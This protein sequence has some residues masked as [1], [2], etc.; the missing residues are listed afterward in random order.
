MSAYVDIINI[1]IIVIVTVVVAVAII[2]MLQIGL[3]IALLSKQFKAI[4]VTKF[5]LRC[6]IFAMLQ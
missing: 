2:I 5:L 4:M 3:G 6:V 1:I